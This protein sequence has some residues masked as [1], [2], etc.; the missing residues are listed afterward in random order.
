[1]STLRAAS[2]SESKS[3]STALRLWLR[4][5]SK[6]S[7]QRSLSLL[8][9]TQVTSA[10]G[11]R[12]KTSKMPSPFFCRAVPPHPPRPALEHQAAGVLLVLPPGGGSG[13]GPRSNS[14]IV[15]P[16]GG[17]SR[18]SPALLQTALPST[19]PS[20]LQQ[21]PNPSQSILLAT[22]IAIDFGKGVEEISK[23]RSADLATT[24]HT[25]QEK[26]GKGEDGGH[27][28]HLSS[29]G[30]L[31]DANRIGRPEHRTTY[32]ITGT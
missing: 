29:N 7:G 20:V 21:H 15:M 22:T 1:M 6:E 2:K 8:E 28:N 14:S 25:T 12:L 24:F 32:Q 9:S 30:S 10:D 31:R 26:G 27:T 18:A 5:L 17:W 3:A 13:F 23:K 11:S 4:A 16:L 19:R